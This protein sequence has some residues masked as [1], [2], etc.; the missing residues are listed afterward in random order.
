MQA[1]LDAIAAGWLDPLPLY[2]H[3]FPLEKLGTA[4]AAV[5][6]RPEGFLKA[7]VSA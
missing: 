2:T 3:T 6:A 5:A 4:M 1:A 7:L